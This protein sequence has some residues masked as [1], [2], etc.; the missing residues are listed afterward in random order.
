[1]AQAADQRR[2]PAEPDPHTGRGRLSEWLAPVLNLP[3]VARSTQAILTVASSLRTDPITLRAAALTYLTVLSVVPLLTVVVSVSQVI[4]GRHEIETRLRD[5]LVQNL[6]GG[7]QASVAPYLTQYIQRA[8]QIGGVGFAFLLVSSIS[9]MANIESAFNHTF[10]VQRPRSLIFR[11]GIYWCL[12][13][14]TPVL[15]ALSLA[16]TAL[17]QNQTLVRLPEPRLLFL[18]PLLLTYLAFFLLYVLVPNA[19]VRRRP[20]LIGAFIAGSAWE[21]AKV[22]YASASASS[23]RQSAIYGSL[24][25]IPIF[26]VWTYLSWIIVLFGARVTYAAQTSHPTG[27][28][29]RIATLLD[30]EILAARVIKAVAAAFARGAVPPVV[31]ALALALQVTTADVESALGRMSGA[32]LV[33]ATAEGGWVPARA[34]ATITLAEVRA[35]AR[36]DGVAR[37]IHEPDLQQRWSRADAAAASELSLTLEDLVRPP[38]EPGLK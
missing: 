18:A 24:S 30:Q 33:R 13:T 15:I 5:F 9:L 36:S 31:D 28:V 2:V 3:G 22:L 10:S 8:S 4:L 7:A 23:V 21:V 32:G 16:A 17:I 19:R 6:T 27:R 34:L 12:L 26:L 14:V 1:M 37:A 35:A 20:A 11:F 25:A 38:T 29:H